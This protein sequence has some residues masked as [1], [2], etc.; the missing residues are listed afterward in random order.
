MKM[1]LQKLFK[2][3]KRGSSGEPLSPVSRPN[4]EHPRTK[5]FQ[6]KINQRVELKRNTA[7]LIGYSS[8][9]QEI[10]EESISVSMPLVGGRYISIL[11]GESLQVTVYET[12]GMYSFTTQVI[13]ID[14]G[15]VPMIKLKKPTRITRVQKRKYIRSNLHLTV[16]YRLLLDN[17][18]SNRS[19]STL[20]RA[21]TRTRNISAGGLCLVMDRDLS[22]GSL[23]ELWIDFPGYPSSIEA[24]AKVVRSE[25]DR[26]SDDYFIRA[27]FT[28]IKSED[29]KYI[30]DYVRYIEGV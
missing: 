16:R 8:R 24:R 26:F 20:V 10:D 12:T 23:I 21:Q 5:V 30:D 1:A 29:R 25:K 4:E 14:E 22:P 18:Q 2:L 19:P 3:F 6:F 9:I 11:V 27:M 13:A 7:D 28:K 15:A 17:S